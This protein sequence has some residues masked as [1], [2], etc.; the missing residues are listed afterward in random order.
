MYCF[1]F[2]S[3]IICILFLYAYQFAYGYIMVRLLTRLKG[4]TYERAA[5]LLNVNNCGVY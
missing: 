1:F 4:G 2:N 5:L 3:F